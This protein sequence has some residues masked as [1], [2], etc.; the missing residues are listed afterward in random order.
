MFSFLFRAPNKTSFLA[1][2]V[3]IFIFVNSLAGI[4][5]LCYPD[6]FPLSTNFT[7]FG[8]SNISYE[9]ATPLFIYFSLLT[10]VYLLVSLLAQKSFRISRNYTSNSSQIS[11]GVSAFNQISLPRRKSLVISFERL[12]TLYKLFYYAFTLFVSVFICVKFFSSQFGFSDRALK[13]PVYIIFPT[14]Y[15]FTVGLFILKARNTLSA[16]LPIIPICALFPFL[17]LFEVTRD[18]IP[19]LFLAFAISLSSNKTLIRNL[20]SLALLI[21]LILSLVFSFI[22]RILPFDNVDFSLYLSNVDGEFFATALLN[23]LFYVTAF[24]FLNVVQQSLYD[25]QSLHS[26]SDLI[27][28][29][30]PINPLL[31]GVN[32]P[33]QAPLFDPVRPYSAF[34]HF[35]SLS[36]LLPLLFIALLAFV[37]T[38]IVV[39]VDNALAFT[40]VIS[41]N[42]L[43]LLSFFQYYPRQSIRFL[44]LLFLFYIYSRLRFSIFRAGR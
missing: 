39:N 40:A 13:F 30:Q 17:S 29:L 10:L 43:F 9:I 23:S 15:G 24:S 7:G 36:P 3:S 33:V 8:L 5:Y 38:R 26:W 41:L 27:W 19:G 37:S 4:A 2:S 1:F 32:S 25:S 22:T 42:L 28:N 20:T 11:Y 34:V 31:F 44:Q 35:Y 12:P 6:L 16:I 21:S 14:L 18:Y